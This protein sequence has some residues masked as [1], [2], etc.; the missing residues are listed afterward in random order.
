MP[1]RAQVRS[2]VDS[3]LSYD[4]IGRRLGVHPGLA[5]MIATGIPADGSDS[6]TETDRARPGFLSTSQHLANPAEAQNPAQKEHVLEWVKQRARSD[7]QMTSAHA[8]RNALPAEP[9][10]PEDDPANDDIITL[11]TRDHNRVTAL[12]KQ[13]S[14]IPGHKKGGSAE[15]IESRHSIVDLIVVALSR[16][17]PAEE[18]HFWPAV[19]SSIE[20]GDALAEKGRSQEQEGAETL[21][22]LTKTPP[23]TDDFDELVEK[24][25]LQLRQHVGYE[26]RV[27][28]ELKEATSHDE[29]IKLGH[30]FRDAEKVWPTEQ[31]GRIEQPG[32]DARS[33]E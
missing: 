4:E 24:L 18:Q 3:G 14:S 22:A 6:L 2:L 13:L 10:Q 26:E 32:D 8:A 29:R 11:I 28:L 21:A 25:V 33:A 23:D 27:L 17:E 19:R 9:P 30:D 12:V 15:Q 7:V 20:G 1:T 31:P 16:H 5:Y